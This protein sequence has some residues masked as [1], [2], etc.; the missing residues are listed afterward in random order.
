MGFTRSRWLDASIASLVAAALEITVLAA[1]QQI[2]LKMYYPRELSLPTRDLLHWTHIPTCYIAEAIQ[3]RFWPRP[4][5]NFDLQRKYVIA[6]G[7]AQMTLYAV[8]LYLAIRRL[9]KTR[10]SPL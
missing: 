5:P 4:Q 9:R 1:I 3:L 8:I 7:L 6:L 2:T 10:I